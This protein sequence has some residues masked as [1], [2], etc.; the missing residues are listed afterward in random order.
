MHVFVVILSLCPYATLETRNSV[1]IRIRIVLCVVRSHPTL[2]FLRCH[3]FDVLL[4]AFAAIKIVPLDLACILIFYR[5]SNTFFMTM[6][7]C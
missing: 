1:T 5:N 4:K 6:N 3:I 7:M 2:L